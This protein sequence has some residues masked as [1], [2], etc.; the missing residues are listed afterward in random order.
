MPEGSAP[1]SLPI[2]LLVGG[3]AALVSFTVVVVIALFRR[4]RR[5]RRASASAVQAQPEGGPADHPPIGSGWPSE[6][7][8]GFRIAAAGS[9]DPKVASV[10]DGETWSPAT[11]SHSAPRE[12]RSAFPSVAAPA[13]DRWSDEGTR[14]SGFAAAE[15]S[16]HL[17]AVRTVE[18][19]REPVEPAAARAPH[20]AIGSVATAAAVAGGAAFGAALGA[21]IGAALALSVLARLLPGAAP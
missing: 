17:D 20:S 11:T 15:R 6:D 3:L 1:V 16:A 9:T 12:S 8:E 14:S 10:G 4:R 7:V 18:A 2:E 21:T 13:P 19:A 5:T